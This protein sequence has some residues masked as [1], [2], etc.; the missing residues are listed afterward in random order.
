M[1]QHIIKLIARFVHADTG[2]PLSD[3]H[4]RVRFYDRDALRDD[5]L[6]ESSLSPQGVAEVISTSGNFQSGLMGLPARLLSEKK[7]DVFCE[8]REKDVP[9]Y[10]SKVAWNVEVER[11]NPITRSPDRTVDLGTFRFRKGEGL[12]DAASGESPKSPLRPNF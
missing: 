5:L 3:P 4:L 7:P 1:S 9:I 6:G 11:V 10:R 8:V 12:T 2:A